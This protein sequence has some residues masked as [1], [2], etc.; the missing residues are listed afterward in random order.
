MEHSVAAID[1]ADTGT[2]DGEEGVRL[3]SGRRTGTP[4]DNS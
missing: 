3:G 4:A 1:T 2:R